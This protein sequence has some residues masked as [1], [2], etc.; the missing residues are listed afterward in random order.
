MAGESA[1][2]A[3]AAENE[4]ALPLNR[5]ERRAKARKAVPSHVGPRQEQER[6]VRGARAR[7]KRAR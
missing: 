7:T 6:Q 2:P 5:A 1:A 3:E 4:T